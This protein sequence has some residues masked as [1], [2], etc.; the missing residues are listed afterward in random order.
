MLMYLFVFLGGISIGSFLNVVIYRVPKGISI[1]KGR[2]YCP[3]C[4][5]QIK[6]YDLIPIVSYLILR[7]RCRTCQ[8]HIELRYLLVELLAGIM[9]CYLCMI[10]GFTLLTLALFVVVAILI[11]IAWIDMDTLT[12]PDS[13]NIALAVVAVFI[14]LLQ[15]EIGIVAR[16]IGFF[17]VSLPMLLIA[18]KIPG[19]FGGGDI[20]LI[21]VCGFILGYQNVILAIFLACV[22]GGIYAI[23]LLRCQ[24]AGRKA[25]M[26][27]GPYIC[28]GTLVAML[29][30]Q[31]I[32]TWYLGML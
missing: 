17:A 2:S 5:T 28:M 18:M 11:A 23:Y 31:E 29:Y 13:L 10:K 20:K 25:E 8:K 9:A 7:G 19:A 21:A 16:I 1:V 26:C 32:I 14:V 27:F 3:N 30:G 22:L 6:N 15:P 24:Q 4:N 12:I